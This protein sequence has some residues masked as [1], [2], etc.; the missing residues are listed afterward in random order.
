MDSTDSSI[1]KPR[2]YLARSNIGVLQGRVY[3]I[4]LVQNKPKFY[5]EKCQLTLNRVLTPLSTASTQ[6]LHVAALVASVG[7][8]AAPNAILGNLQSVPSRLAR[9]RSC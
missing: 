9:Q 3:N 7:T 1:C 5:R 8:K 4:D 2:L 6:Y